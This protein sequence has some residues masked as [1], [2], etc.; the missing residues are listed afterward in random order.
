MPN[1]DLREVDFKPPKTLQ[2][3]WDSF[4]GGLN[5]L[6]RQTEIKDNELAQAD[7]LKLVGRGVPTKREGTADYFLTGASVAT[8]TQM[9]RGLK[10]VLF[11]SGASGINEL[12][13][14]SDHG[15]LVKKNGAS[16]SI[17]PGYS[18]A[19]GYNAEMIQAFNNVYITNGS[20]V[21]TKYGGASIN[22][23][24]QISKPTGV[25][26]TNISGVTGTFTRSFRISA[27]NT[28]G[29][30]IASDAVLVTFTPQDLTQTTIRLNWTTSSPASVVVGYG[31]YGID[32]GDE[33]LITTLD[34]STTEYHYQGIPDPALFVFPSAADTTQ[35][36]VAKYII[37]HKD[38]IVL[39]NVVNFPS[40]IAWSG[41]GVNIDKFNWRY[42]GGY[43]DIDKD[44]GDVVTGLVEF[45]DSIVVFKERSVWQV[46]LA[47]D[48]DTG[49]VI[50]TVKM[51][52]RG[53][54]AVS[55]RSIRHVENDVFFLSRRGVFSLGNEANYLANVL[56]TN[57]LSVKLRPIFSTLSP[58]Q[59]ESACAVYQDTKYRLS[60][61]TGGSTYNDKEII[62]DRERLAWMGPNNYP[63]TASVYEVYYDGAGIENLVWGDSN[64]NFVTDFKSDYANDK[65]IRIATSLL[66]KK[67]FFK[68]PFRY[69]QVKNV[70]SNWRNV[71]GNPFVKIYLEGRDGQ[72][73]VAQNFN[74]TSSSAGVGW[75]FDKWGT[76]K[77]G[78]TAGAGTA[79]GSSDIVK[80]TRLNRVGRT[81]QV[82]ITTQGTND[83]YE[84]LGLQLE[85]N[86]LGPGIIPS[87]WDTE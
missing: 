43:I 5:T 18:Y 76:F 22:S 44:S 30:T 60:F 48:S 67:T 84:L 79:I 82:E 9:V 51:I 74:I 21:L 71:S 64:D 37:N 24:T 38:K 11:T 73:A 58:S 54:G 66:T 23:Y 55:H 69:K 59:L 39:G 4:R 27:F 8:G 53:V 40:R 12:L 77:W 80:R 47:Y 83:K 85:A 7:N 28:V 81:V 31:I 19:S 57:E 61:P 75:G 72:T 41:G 1:L 20:D 42:G 3:D 32:Q 65:G 26:A 68:N 25:T 16:Y 86:E 15:Y 33:R 29:E 34:P 56:R 17:V 6:L 46:T 78:T 10:G 87:S 45:Q 52:I 49:I 2:L 50:P 70:F 62:Y 63:A 35:G 13:A 36:P 14:I